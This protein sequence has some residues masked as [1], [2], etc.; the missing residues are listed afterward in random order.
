MTLIAKT[1]PQEPAIFHKVNKRI[2]SCRKCR[3]WEGTCNAV[4]GEGPTSAR[5]MLIGQNPGSEEDKTGRPFVGRSGMY[6]NK[7]LAA[8]G[9]RREDI[10]ITVLVK[11]HSP[12]NRKPRADEIAVCMPYTVEQMKLIRPAVILLMGEVAWMTP[13]IEGIRYIETYHPAA[14]MRFPKVRIKFEEDLRKLKTLF[15]VGILQSI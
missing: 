10:F 7:V 13:R 6:L 2:M 1:M 8:N 5:L 14:A 3:L 11:H 9:I 15:N 4:P 12:R